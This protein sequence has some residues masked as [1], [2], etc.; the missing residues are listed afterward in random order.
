MARCVADGQKKNAANRETKNAAERAAAHQPIVHDDQPADSHHRSP[1]EG[2]VI[3]D[4]QLA[5]ELG[6]STFAI[7]ICVTTTG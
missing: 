6:H 7:M 1:S 3:G 2:E 5:G 4:A